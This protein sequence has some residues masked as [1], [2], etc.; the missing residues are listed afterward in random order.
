MKNIIASYRLAFHYIFKDSTNFL[1][2]MIPIGLGIS[3]YAFLGSWM[4]GTGMEQGQEWIQ[5]HIAS[6]NWGTIVYYLAITLLT[7][8]FFL[9]VNWTFV[10]VVSLL[11]APF[12]DI[13]S[14][15]I[16]RMHQGKECEKLHAMIGQMG[17]KLP[18]ILWN[19][20]KKIS[21]LLI[22]I[23]LSFLLSL[24][25]LLVPISFLL[26][27]LIF[28]A[29]YL[30]YSWSRY[31]VP[32]KKCFISLQKSWIT[33]SITGFGYILLLSI[34]LVNLFVISLAVSHY[35]VLFID[36]SPKLLQEV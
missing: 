36:N 28:S 33:Y 12:N 27:A 7:I 22:L 8:F 35:T 23:T 24:I 2:A 21:M 16:D 4:F 30:D 20:I 32:A 31:D 13:L 6:Q 17:A 5:S 29:G 10:L 19:E 34:P 14:R 1:L 25:P 3:L 15:R 26:S 9:L 18:A 11:A